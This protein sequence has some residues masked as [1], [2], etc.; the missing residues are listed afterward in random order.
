M[1][2]FIKTEKNLTLYCKG[3]TKIVPIGT[4][5]YVQVTK[6]IKANAPEKD[7][8]GACDLLERVKLKCHESGLFSTDENGDVW[9]ESEKVA[10]TLSDRI[11]DFA[12]Q[13][14]PVEPLVKFWHNCMLNPDPRARTDLFAY[15][16]VNGHPVTEDGC[17][18]SY[19]KVTDDFK[20]HRTKTFD[21]RIGKTVKED[22][23]L[24]DPDPKNTCSKGLHVA[25]MDYVWGFGSGY[26]I[27]VKVNPRDVVAIPSD[28]DQKKMRVCEYT[29]LSMKDGGKE[30]LDQSLYGHNRTKVKEAEDVD[31]ADTSLD[32]V[33]KPVLTNT[34]KGTLFGKKPV[35][36]N[37]HNVRGKD[38]RFKPLSKA[39]KAGYNA[40][41]KKIEKRKVK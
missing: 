40:K 6:L 33:T 11:L 17:F 16:E 41:L 25:S 22:R 36:P 14:L 23:R 21:N 28:Y 7:I 30:P 34:Y 1:I 5:A 4:P 24:Q 31:V 27:C 39:F 15:M 18:I 19:K 26:N 35:Q 32:E 10:R 3:V 38:G 29:V 12:E 2:P 37:F 8:I 20:D 13:G 9:V